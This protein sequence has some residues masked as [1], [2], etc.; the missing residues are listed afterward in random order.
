MQNRFGIQSGDIHPLDEYEL[1]GK[2]RDMAVL[3][4]RVIRQQMRTVVD[5][6]TKI[7]YPTKDELTS[8][9]DV[10]IGLVES[11]LGYAVDYNYFVS[12]DGE[13]YSALYPCYKNKDGNIAIETSKYREYNIDFA[14]RNWK[15]EL[16]KEALDYLNEIIKEDNYIMDKKKDKLMK[17]TMYADQTGQYTEDEIM[18]CNCVEVEIPESILREF[19]EEMG[20]AI[21]FTGD[22]SDIEPSFENWIHCVYDNDSTEG[23]YDFAVQRGFMP[24]CGKNCDDWTWY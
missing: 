5:D 18:W 22:Y 13:Q 7:Y 21:D 17:V 8:E 24:I 1:A 16:I 6:E 2:E 23:L 15:N 11:Q 4:G 19:Y 14:N 9:P 12:D 3:I 20:C 10:W